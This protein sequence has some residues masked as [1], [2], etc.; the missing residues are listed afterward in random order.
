MNLTFCVTSDRIY[1]M[2]KGAPAGLPLVTGELH[3]TNTTM[4][5]MVTLVQVK[6]ACRRRGYAKAMLGLLEALKGEAR[7][8]YLTPMGVKWW[9]GIGRK[10]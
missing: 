2:S 4:G 8:D 7:P 10:T 5:P 9:R 3:W 6:P 1:L